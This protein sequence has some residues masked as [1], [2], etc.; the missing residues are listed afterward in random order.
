MN[1]FST[2]A[3]EFHRIDRAGILPRP[4]RR[5]I[6]VWFGGGAE[7]S[8]AR[9]A[10]TGDGFVFGSAGPRTHRRAARLHEL[11]AGEGRDPSAF[12]MEAMIDYTL[13]PQAWTAEVAARE[14][15]GGSI[16]SVQTMSTGTGYDRAA[17]QQLD[18]PAAHIAA[19]GEFARVVRGG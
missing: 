5:T 14:A 13:G 11:L 3:V 7:V 17:H 6:P 12:P 8:L 4:G 10:R 15:R 9:A 19:L 1:P 18:S 2:T 16:L